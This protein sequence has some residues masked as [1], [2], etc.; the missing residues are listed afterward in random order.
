MG[1]GKSTVGR[2]LADVTGA[3]FV[4]LDVR[5]E[6]MFGRSVVALLEDSEPG[7]RRAETAALRSLIAEPGFSGRS[8]VVATGG[9][10]VIDAA[11][12]ACM[13]ASGTIVFLEVAASVLAERLG[14]DNVPTLSRPLLGSS[15]V[16]LPHRISE[17]LA[18]RRGAYADCALRI[19]AG[20][21]PEQVVATVQQAVQRLQ[22]SPAALA[23]SE[24]V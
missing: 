18:A 10:A 8:V 4:D 11:N 14:A 17:L 6:R 20:A 21:A 23:D 2:L 13:R 3:T 15:V 1:S 12:R 9:G 24:A 5:I 19:D 16:T 7:F 22:D